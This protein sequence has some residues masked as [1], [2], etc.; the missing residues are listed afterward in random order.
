[1]QNTTTEYTKRNQF[2][3]QFSTVEISDALNVEYVSDHLSEINVR[4]SDYSK[5]R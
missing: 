5:M 4:W 3:I 1:M 2:H